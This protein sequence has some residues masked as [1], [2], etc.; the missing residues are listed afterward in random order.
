KQKIDAT[1]SLIIQYQQQQQKSTPC[2][3]K[4]YSSLLLLMIFLTI[5]VASRIIF[6]Q[7]T[8]LGTSGQ[9]I[10]TQLRRCTIRGG[11]NCSPLIFFDIITRTAYTSCRSSWLNSLVFT[12]IWRVTSI[13][14]TI[15]SSG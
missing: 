12:L 4:K 8:A 5:V 7:L 15:K 9:Y 10:S 13:A 11:I 6:E 3:K 14:S 1:A 2:D